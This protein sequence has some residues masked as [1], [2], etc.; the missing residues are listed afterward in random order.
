MPDS[1]YPFTKCADEPWTVAG[2]PTIKSLL[3]SLVVETLRKGSALVT[4]WSL[5]LPVILAG[6]DAI[7]CLQ[8]SV[9]CSSRGRNGRLA[10]TIG[11]HRAHGCGL[12]TNHQ[13]A[14]PV[15]R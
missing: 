3:T 15:D 2:P 4:S 8:S 13:F 1:P 7:F 10:G 14:N 9:L 11:V 12:R 6:A 5:A